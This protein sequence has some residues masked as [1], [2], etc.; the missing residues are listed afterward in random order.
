MTQGLLNST[1][2][3]LGESEFEWASRSGDVSDSCEQERAGVEETLWV[4]A[5]ECALGIAR[6]QPAGWADEAKGDEFVG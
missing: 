2:N 4:G 5:A 1:R 3:C 6:G